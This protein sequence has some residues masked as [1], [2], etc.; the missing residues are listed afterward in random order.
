LTSPILQSLLK[1]VEPRKKKEQVQDY[2]L[3]HF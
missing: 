1:S 2:K 3:Y